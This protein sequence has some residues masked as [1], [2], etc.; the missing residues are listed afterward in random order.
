[1]KKDAVIRGGMNYVRMAPAGFGKESRREKAQI[2][3]VAG[4]LIAGNTGLKHFMHDI[5]A[6]AIGYGTQNFHTDR[7]RSGW[8]SQERIIIKKLHNVKKKQFA[9]IYGDCTKN[10]ILIN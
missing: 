9:K 7:F 10:I 4:N 1:M 2:G 5:G 3:I 8:S 6:T